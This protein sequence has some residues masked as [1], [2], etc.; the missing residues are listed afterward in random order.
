[1]TDTKRD[2]CREALAPG[3][4]LVLVGEKI[5]PGK[6]VMRHAETCVG[7]IAKK[8]TT[9]QR[10][11]KARISRITKHDTPTAEGESQ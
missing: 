11:S 6:Y 8:I 5:P 7:V 9:K 1:M 10:I 3:E 4:F 2:T